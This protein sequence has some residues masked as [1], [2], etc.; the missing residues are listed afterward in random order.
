MAEYKMPDP[1]EG[2]YWLVKYCEEAAWTKHFRVGLY[3]RV[4]TYL[5]RLSR[6]KVTHEKCVAYRYANATTD[7]EK[8]ARNVLDEAKGILRGLEDEKLLKSLNG[9]TG[10]ERV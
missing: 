8:N 10:Y 7:P 5:S 1:P 6:R 9:L 3:Y 2:M 4:E